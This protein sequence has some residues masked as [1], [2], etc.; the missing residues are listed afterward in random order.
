MCL[1]MRSHDHHH[2]GQPRRDF[3]ERHAVRRQHLRDLSRNLELSVTRPESMPR[4]IGL[5]HGEQRPTMS[6]S[7]ILKRREVRQ[8]R[9]EACS[10]MPFSCNCATSAS[11]RSIRSVTAWLLGACGFGRPLRPRG[12]RCRCTAVHWI[13]ALRQ[14][15]H[16]TCLL[17]FVLRRWHCWQLSWATGTL[18]S[19]HGRAK[20]VY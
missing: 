1:K 8:V 6:I 11:R 5:I 18:M 16:G 14:A 20:I 2:T 9:T 4:E 7:F 15:E 3:R 13:S 12:S 17:H 10:E 19:I